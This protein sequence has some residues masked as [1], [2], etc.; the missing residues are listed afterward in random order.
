MSTLPNM[1]EFLAKYV[2]RLLDQTA[3]AVEN[4]SAEQLHFRPHEDTN[5]IGFDAWHVAR[6]VDNIVN[7][8]FSRTPPVWIAQGLNDA[9]NLPKADQGTGMDP[10]TAHDLQFPDAKLLAKY[11]RVVSQS[12]VPQ[13]SNMSEEVLASTMV[14]KPQG[15]MAKADILMQ[16]LIVHCH[17]HLGHINISLTAQGIEGLGI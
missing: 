15:E 3:A 9:W 2:E 17:G 12:V 10:A 7:F 13:I 14:I 4:L 1:N 16:V 6:T 5:S 11:A 8:A